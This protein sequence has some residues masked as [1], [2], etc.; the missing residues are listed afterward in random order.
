MK[1]FRKTQNCSNCLYCEQY[2]NIETKQ[3]SERLY[4]EWYAYF[5]RKPQGEDIEVP[6]LYVCDDWEAK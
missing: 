4:Q 3:V 1:N 6:A 2:D 5:C